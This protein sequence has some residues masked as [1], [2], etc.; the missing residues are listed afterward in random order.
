MAT[1]ANLSTIEQKALEAVRDVLKD[2]VKPGRLIPIRNT[3]S[4]YFTIRLDDRRELC[5][6]VHKPSSGKLSYIGCNRTNEGYFKEEISSPDEIHSIKNKLVYK[7]KAIAREENISLDIKQESKEENIPSDIKQEEPTKRKFVCHYTKMG[8]LK[9]IFLPKESEDRK[10]NEGKIKLRFTNIR[11]LN[12][13]AEGFVFKKF[14]ENYEMKR[15]NRLPEETLEI[16]H[17]VPKNTDDLREGYIFSMSNLMDSFAFW[18]TE[19]AG[20][21]GIVIVFYKSETI[22][23]IKL[24]NFDTRDVCYVNLYHQEEK[25]EEEEDDD[26]QK[27]EDDFIKD[28]VNKMSTSDK[29]KHSDTIGI[30]SLLYKQKSW[31]HENEMRIIITKPPIPEIEIDSNSIKKCCYEYFDASIVSHI[32]LGPKCNEEQKK[33]VEEYLS[34]NGYNIPVTRSRAFELLN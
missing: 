7:L 20:L 10:F 4:H 29:E 34:K 23:T 16:I 22:G 2:Y 14:L 21:D 15:K 24:K 19:Y 25:F 12:D 32:M 6:I 17:K 1:I 31:K 5:F 30:F 26:A 13:P 33:A 8:S 3:Q 28:F 11:F 18:N 27:E 9:K